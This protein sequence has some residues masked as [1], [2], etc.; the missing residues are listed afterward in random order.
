MRD[1]RLRMIDYL[2]STMHCLSLI[3]GIIGDLEHVVSGWSEQN[4]K[5]K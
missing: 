3:D 5:Q 2:L 1:S 4:P